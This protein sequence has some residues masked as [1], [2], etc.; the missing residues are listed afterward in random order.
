MKTRTTGQG[1]D[2]RALRVVGKP[3]TSDAKAPPS[4]GN[5]LATPAESSP[6]LPADVRA[7]LV[8]KL[9]EMLVPDYQEN[10]VVLEPSVVAP[11]GINRSSVRRQRST[12]V[13]GT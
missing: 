13:Q 3:Q 9:A 10:Q 11:G 12:G 8:E 1:K 7:F 4:A 2:Q 5:E 6:G